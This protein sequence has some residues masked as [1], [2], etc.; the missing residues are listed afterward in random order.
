MDETGCIFFDVEM[1]SVDKLPALVGVL[2]DDEFTITCLD[3]RLRPVAEHSDLEVRDPYAFFEEL[4]LNAE[5]ED[6]ALVAYSEH[7]KD[8]LV[9]MFG[10]ENDRHQQLRNIVERRYVNANARKWFRKHYRE[11]YDMIEAREKAKGRRSKYRKPNGTIRMGLNLL[12]QIPE[13]AYPGVGEAGR[14]S[15]AKTLYD[16]RDHL[17]RKGPSYDS[18]TGTV[19]RKWKNLLNYLRHD[20]VGMAHLYAFVQEREAQWADMMGAQGRRR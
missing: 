12:L 14:G 5:E 17:E 16:V 18:L 4:I 11:S 1:R 15:P 8:L 9:E 10:Q 13:V 2:I 3:E 20:V 7:E 6:M 19:K